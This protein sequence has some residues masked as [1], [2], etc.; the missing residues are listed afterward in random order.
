MTPNS[1]SKM[2]D[3]S[4]D[5][6]DLSSFPLLRVDQIHFHET[7]TLLESEA[8]LQELQSENGLESITPFLE[9]L[10]VSI[11]KEIAD[12]RANEG[13]IKQ[14]ATPPK[15]TSTKK[16]HG[17]KPSWIGNRSNASRT[18]NTK[19]NKVVTFVSSP[20]SSSNFRSRV[21]AAKESLKSRS[22]ISTL[23]QSEQERAQRI[24]QALDTMQVWRTERD[25][26]KAQR[27]ALFEEERL[28]RQRRKVRMEREKQ[29]R[30][31]M[32][33][34]AEEAKS[35]ALALGCTEEEAIVEAAAAATQ[36]ANLVDD[37]HSLLFNSSLVDSDDDTYLDNESEGEEV[38]PKVLFDGVSFTCKDSP[39]IG[40]E[41]RYERPS[42]VT[43]DVS[44]DEIEST[45]SK[46]PR[47]SPCK[48]DIPTTPTKKSSS[49]ERAVQEPELHHI[50]QEATE[51]LTQLPTEKDQL[52]MT[53]MD[54]GDCLQLSQT[55][56]DDQA[57]T[58]SAST[59]T[60][61]DNKA[62][63][64]S[65]ND[66][67]SSPCQK[68]EQIPVNR[69]KCRHLCDLFPTFSSIFTKFAKKGRSHLDD[70]TQKELISCM[71]HQI[72]LHEQ[73]RPCNCSQ[74]DG[75]SSGDYPES[76]RF[77]RINSR[78][79]EVRTLLDE[80]F[81]HFAFAEWNEL[82]HHCGDSWNLLWTWGLPKAS[83]F[84]NLL[85]FQ[86]VNRFRQT[87]GLTRKDLL[88]KN[89][90]RNASGHLMPLTYALPHEYNAFVCGYSTIQKTIGFSPNF[91][92]VKPIG[93]SRG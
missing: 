11:R 39:V 51:V 73:L 47:H 85:V 89:M 28:Q 21:K 14:L 90:Q 58:E 3:D 25:K 49:H 74:I 68:D 46:E 56:G 52:T 27:D 70:S 65:N 82:P 61:L 35:M 88:Q 33:A 91:W 84:D 64:T 26:S 6:V 19:T 77:Y 36:A 17:R 12:R 13:K 55:C 20:K 69:D 1:R 54:E 31:S 92:I 38:L 22:Q 83:V 81:S 75:D 71:Q 53:V 59:T 60:S 34:A 32:H 62:K 24:R 44:L 67:R 45:E 40:E 30:D 87:K 93:L 37:S 2:Q 7:Q 86:K 10:L 80:V 78:R 5:E 76:Y 41:K 8:Q 72:K 43:I 4:P 23:E 63:N 16:P 48:K 50:G 15:P 57:V 9:K 79:S 66:I 29:V 18:T 42:A